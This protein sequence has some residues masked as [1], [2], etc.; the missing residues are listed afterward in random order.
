MK[1]YI[2]ENEKILAFFNNSMIFGYKYL[3]NNK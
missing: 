2:F 1:V 3:A